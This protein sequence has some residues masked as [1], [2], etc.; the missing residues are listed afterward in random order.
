MI[1][2]QGRDSYVFLEVHNGNTMGN[3]HFRIISQQKLKYMITFAVVIMGITTHSF[4]GVVLAV[5]I[6]FFICFFLA[7]SF[8]ILVLVDNLKRLLDF[9]HAIYLN[10]LIDIYSKL[11]IQACEMH[12]AAG[13]DPSS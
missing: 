12:L 8:G 7:G 1:Y 13:S 2:F 6:C 4:G 10:S 11:C 5:F 3:G 9:F